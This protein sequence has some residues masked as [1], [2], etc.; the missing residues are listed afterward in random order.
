MNGQIS[1]GPPFSIRP[2]LHGAEKA[3]EEQGVAAGGGRGAGVEQDS[4][5]LDLLLFGFV[6]C[7]GGVGSGAFAGH[8]R[9]V[10]SGGVNYTLVG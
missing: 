6:F 8:S 9:G 7:G 2:L 4:F 3:R 5:F 10:V 1:F